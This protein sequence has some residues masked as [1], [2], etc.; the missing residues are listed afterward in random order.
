[1]SDVPR[2]SN[3]AISVQASA[4]KIVQTVCVKGAA[5]RE[6]LVLTSSNGKPILKSISMKHQSLCLDAAISLRV[7]RLMD[8]LAWTKYTGE[9]RMGNSKAS[10][11]SLLL[12]LT[13]Y[14]RAQTVNSLFASS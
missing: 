4:G 7:N 5:T 1:M 9:I 2:F 13:P 14:P 11:M 10:E 3:A 12:L 8:S 6:T